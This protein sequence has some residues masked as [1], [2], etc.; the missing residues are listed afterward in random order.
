MTFDVS[1]LTAREMAEA[2]AGA[3]GDF[4]VERIGR[5]VLLEATLQ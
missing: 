3:G 2:F 1:A 5:N 4:F